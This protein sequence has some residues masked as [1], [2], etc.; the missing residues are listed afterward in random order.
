M[1]KIL[2]G[3]T[4]IALVCFCAAAAIAVIWPHTLD[5]FTAQ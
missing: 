3:G 5:I 2:R 4:L 1:K